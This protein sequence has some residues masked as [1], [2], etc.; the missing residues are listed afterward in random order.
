MGLFKNGELKEVKATRPKAPKST[1]KVKN[2]PSKGASFW[3]VDTKN[4][5]ETL[6]FS[7]SISECRDYIY[8]ASKN[9]FL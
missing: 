4:E 6:L 2:D 3:V 1:L 9:L 5:T 7:G 8:F